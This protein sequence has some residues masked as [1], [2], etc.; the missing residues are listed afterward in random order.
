MQLQV[1]LVTTPEL[2]EIA[3]AIRIKV[4]VD[5]QKFDAAVE[6]DELD[7]HPGMRHFVGAI[8]DADS[9]PQYIAVARCMIYPELK[10]GKIGRVA[11]LPEYRGKRIG[12]LVMEQLENLVRHEVEYFALHAQYDKK[13]FYEKCGYS[14]PDGKIF[15]EEGVEHC[16]MTKSAA[17]SD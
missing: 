2:L 3:K 9:K 7:D 15:L 8:A 12:Y 6:I 10:K 5:E 4:F 1:S 11:V 17:L 14:C 13:T 16:L